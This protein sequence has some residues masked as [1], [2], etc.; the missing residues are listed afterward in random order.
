MNFEKKYIT[1]CVVSRPGHEVEVVS[2]IQKPD[3]RM[4]QV[5]VQLK[6]AS[7]CHSQLMEARGSRGEDKYL[8]HLFGH[9]GIGS[10]VEVGFGVT[11]VIVGDEVILTWVKDTGIEAGATSY[12]TK[13]GRRINSGSVVTLATFAVVSEN[14]VVK[15][16]P[17]TPSW[18]CSLYGCAMLTGAGIVMNQVQPRS[19]SDI[20]VLG[21]GGVGLSAL[22]AAKSFRPKSLIAIDTEDHKLDL[23]MSLGADKVVKVGSGSDITSSINKSL[24]G[25]GADYVIESAG[26]IETIE[27]GFSLLKKESGELYFA[28][29]PAAGEKISLDPFELISGKKIFGSWGGGS[30]PS[31]DIPILDKMYSKGFF[32]LEKL[33]SR[34]YTLHEINDALWDLEN[35]KINRALIK[36]N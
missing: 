14:R 35:R 2:D 17:F 23:A 10:V 12:V 13:S 28:S 8:P 31:R 11:K 18:L 36:I 1:G 15:K 25:A 6:Y 24:E 3:L 30:I 34:E 26:K 19:N 20:V 21:L 9:E 7:V 4:G 22:M 27:L 29:H 5:L 16:P 32:D 33:L